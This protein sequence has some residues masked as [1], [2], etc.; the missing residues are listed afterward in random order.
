MPCNSTL[1]RISASCSASRLASSDASVWRRFVC[2]QRIGSVIHQP[3]C[4]EAVIART[5]HIAS[6]LIG[7]LLP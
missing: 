7:T 3:C 6:F 5:L 2:T 4:A 1:A